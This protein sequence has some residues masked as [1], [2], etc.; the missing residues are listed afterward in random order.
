M[1][2]LM[3]DP[4]IRVVLHGGTA[5][6]VSLP[7]LYA[8]LAADQVADLPALRPHQAPPL[9][10]LLVQLAAVACDVADRDEAPGDDPEAWAALLRS[11]TEDWPGDEPWSLTA[12]PDLPAF[13]QPPAADGLAAYKGVATT[14]DA[15]DMLV[16]SKNHDLKVERMVAA[17]PD[18]W[19]FALVSLQTQEGFLGAG[20]YGV[21]RMNGGFGSRPW[22][23]LSPAG[24]GFGAAVMRDL[25]VLLGTR[26]EALEDLK[27]RFGLGWRASYDLL[28]LQPWDGTASYGL[29]DLHPWFVEVSRRVRLEGGP[30]GALFA[31]TAGSKAPRVGDRERLGV[32][33]D[34][35]APVEKL[36]PPK[37]LTIGADGFTYRRMV[38]LLFSPGKRQYATP[39][40]ARPSHGER[41]KPMRLWAAAL[42]RGQ[43]KTEG[44]HTFG[45]DMPPE[46]VDAWAQA[47]DA[48]DEEDALLRRR[49]REQM[50]MAGDVD[51]RALRPA[52]VVLVQ[53][54]PDEPDWRKPSNEALVGPHRRRFDAGV[55][56]DFFHQLWRGL[57]ADDD[58]ARLAW[59]RTL[60]ALARGA[61]RAAVDA[62]PRGETSRVIAHA[63]ARNLLEGAL[64]KL[65]PAGALGPEPREEAQDGPV[66]A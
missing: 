28:W 1:H 51:G 64:R 56:R 31:R 5:Q 3:A 26:G 35:W 25:R 65:L 2:N 33:G 12:P 14:P 62:T 29:A 39:L 22:L 55:E 7:V 8:A 10:A 43:G 23:G 61:L 24:G 47:V 46:A 16:T 54:G 58:G 50:R 15:L 37:V 27:A 13:L 48:P 38:D 19:L 18:A 34:P 40:L 41:S 42:A 63:R 30:D 21:A 52:L 49:A 20:N 4:V 9:H 11:L 57:Q 32:L 59:A 66:A 6:A 36:D 44:F 45:I 53:G 60:A 17:G